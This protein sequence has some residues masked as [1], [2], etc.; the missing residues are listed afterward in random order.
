MV[1]SVESPCS[2]QFTHDAMR[3]SLVAACV[4]VV[5]PGVAFGQNPAASSTSGE[6]GPVPTNIKFARCPAAATAADNCVS[7]DEDTNRLPN[8]SP[9]QWL[10]GKDQNAKMSQQ[11][12]HSVSMTRAQMPELQDMQPIPTAVSPEYAALMRLLVPPPPPSTAPTAATRNLTPAEEHAV[13]VQ[14]NRYLVEEWRE[15]QLQVA[16]SVH[17]DVLLR[18]GATFDSAQSTGM[19]GSARTELF[20]RLDRLAKANQ[21]SWLLFRSQVNL[22]ADSASVA[23]LR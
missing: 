22:R 12:F 19:T 6:N 3:S 4:L 14:A 2:R 9:T 18:I 16:D 20:E 11:S 5:L 23:P 8:L 7:P 13:R 17:H 15:A 21:Y 1:P 10:F